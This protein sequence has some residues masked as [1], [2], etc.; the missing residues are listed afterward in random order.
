MMGTMEKV[1]LVFL[2]KSADWTA[3]GRAEIVFELRSVEWED[4]I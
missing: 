2:V 1:C 3:L 4:S